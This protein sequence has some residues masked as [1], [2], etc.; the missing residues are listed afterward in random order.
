VPQDIP[1]AFLARDI[2]P[3][4]ESPKVDKLP[5]P[6]AKKTLPKTPN[7]LGSKDT[8]AM[9]TP[10]SPLAGDSR[11]DAAHQ[12]PRLDPA[13]HQDASPA[14]PKSFG[15]GA[16]GGPQSGEGSSVPRLEKQP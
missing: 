6:S 15:L 1:S 11:R 3:K 9:S 2:H 12:S 4:G 16:H 13:M 8:G 7:P 10:T 5:S 14:S